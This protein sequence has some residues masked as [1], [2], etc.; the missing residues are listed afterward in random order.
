MTDHATVLRQQLIRNID[1]VKLERQQRAP[2]YDTQC[3]GVSTG[4]SP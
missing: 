3:G 2:L 4:S 1:E